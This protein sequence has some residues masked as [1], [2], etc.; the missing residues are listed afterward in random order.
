VAREVASF[1][2]S[3]IYD[4][5]VTDQHGRLIAEFRGHSRTVKGTHVPIP[6]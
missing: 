2:R 1:G 4:I 6:E 5:R 3:G